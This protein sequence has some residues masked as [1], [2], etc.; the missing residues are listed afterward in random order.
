M[1]DEFE[2]V[3]MSD[4]ALI[5][6]V[7]VSNS[8]EV[9]RAV[10]SNLW[11]WEQNA[12]VGTNSNGRESKIQIYVSRLNGNETFVDEKKLNGVRDYVTKR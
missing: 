7:N 11:D 12:N 3:D 4:F 9:M 5:N 8:Q 10:D 1:L 2:D 6:N